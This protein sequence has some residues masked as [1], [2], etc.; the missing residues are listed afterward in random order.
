[1]LPNGWGLF[2]MHGNMWEWCWDRFA[3]YSEVAVTDPRGPE[4]GQS[5]LLRGGAWFSSPRYC[6][7]AGRGGYHPTDRSGFYGLRVVCGGV[8]VAARTP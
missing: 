1:L 2:D 5:R 7:S 8:G 6:G 4:T 3:A